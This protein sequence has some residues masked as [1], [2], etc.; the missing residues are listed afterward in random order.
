MNH[1]QELAA[2]IIREDLVEVAQATIDYLERHPEKQ[3]TTVTRVTPAK[4]LPDEILDR[5]AAL[6][7]ADNATCWALGDLVIEAIDECAGKLSKSEIRTQIANRTRYQPSGI[8][9]REA[10]SRFWDEA[11]REEYGVLDWSHF[12]LAMRQKDPRGDL[13]YCIE[14]A[15]R[16]GGRPM[17]YN[18][19]AQMVRERNKG[20]TYEDPYDL[21]AK[22]A[23]LLSR[24]LDAE[25][26][27]AKDR[28]VWQAAYDLL[29]EM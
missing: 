7:D 14:S 18:A 13:R 29:S 15:D 16:Y 26:M 3:V 1:V 4:V 11:D 20:K 2:Q 28:K 24:A 9:A 6:S 27:P 25:H 8:R 22:A 21:A 17:P 19:Y 12:R 5:A 23:T 10:V